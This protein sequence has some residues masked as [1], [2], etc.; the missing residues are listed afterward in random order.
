M[1]VRELTFAI[2]K[3]GTLSAS[4]VFENRR[5]GNTLHKTGK[6]KMR[7]KTGL[8]LVSTTVLAMAISHQA[9][10]QAVDYGGLESMFGEAVTTSATGSPQKASQAPANLEIITADQ[11]RQSGA[12]DIPGILRFAAGIDVRSNSALASDVSIRGNS[13]E[14]NPRVLVLINGRQVYLDDYGYTAWQTLPV[15]LSEIRQIEIVKGPASALFGF[16]AASGVINIITYDPLF[17]KVN[18]ATIGYGTDGTILGS[19]V[20]TGQV[21]GKGGLRIS[22]GGIKTNEYSTLGHDVATLNTTAP[23]DGN[24]N[25]RGEWKPTAKTEITAEVTDSQAN[26]LSYTV[27][28]NMGRNIYRTDSALLGFSADTDYGLATV[29]GYVNT[30]VDKFASAGLAGRVE[31][32]IAVLQANDLVKIGDSNAVRAGLEYRDNREW[33][34]LLNGSTGYQDY[35]ASLMWTWQ[36][37]PELSL[38]NAGRI[39]RLDLNRETPLVQPNKY[40]LGQFQSATVTAPSFNSGLVYQPT[41][42]DTFRLL[43]GRGVQ[44]PSLIDY[45]LQVGQQAGPTRV[46][47]SGSPD[48]NASTTTNY[49]LDYDRIVPA[50]QST[51]R[52]AVYYEVNRDLLASPTGTPSSYAN[53][54][55]SAYSQN[56]G[57]DTVAGAEIGL[58]GSN[59]AGMRWNLSYSLASVHQKLISAPPVIPYN[60]NNAT[61]VSAVDFG[62]GYSWN[63]FEADLQGKW[64]SSYTDYASGAFGYAPVHIANYVTLNARIGYS[65]TPHLT[66]ALAGSQLASN[67]LNETAG[68]PVDRRALLTA[69]YGF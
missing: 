42:N 45:G 16:N 58:T 68:L 17:D 64:Q 28:D 47:F 13:Q 6:L 15:E 41:D 46:V 2:T 22:L 53:G 35:A 34:N 12:T 37:T 9:R 54:V 10:A 36:I 67:S 5:F 60:F 23:R 4:G 7:F 56:I 24:L 11:I 40:T 33:S 61:P 3:P 59:P 44:A 50:L 55:V 32:Q 14:F 49:E 8:G 52:T 27:L 43:L 38:T 63:K 57:S 20:A 1:A 25:I 31:N 30:A 51:L 62:V 48:L 65:V 19:V 66:V 18:T 29:Q 26:S 39:D 69:T 21:A